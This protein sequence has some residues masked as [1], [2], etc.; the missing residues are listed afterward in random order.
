[1]KQKTIAILLV[2]C[3]L[4]SF[5]GC[6]K[7]SGQTSVPA[8]STD[9]PA[10]TSGGEYDFP[11]VRFFDA[12]LLDGNAVTAN[13]LYDGKDLTVINCWATWCPPC[14]DEMDE[15]A[16]FAKTLPDNVQLITYCVDGTNHAEECASILEEAGC[17]GKTIVSANGDFTTFI[18]QMQYV[19]TTIF[20]DSAGGQ[21][22]DSLIGSPTDL[23]AAYKERINAALKAAGKQGL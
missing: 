8:V 2:L 10:E 13:E 12:T 19:P 7:E 4:V 21:T 5:S 3:L 1:M 9:A 6:S 15:L 20:V 14:L 23:E 17:E 16:A 11:D 18:E 22:C